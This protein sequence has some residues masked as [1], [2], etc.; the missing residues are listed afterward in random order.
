MKLD[1]STIRLS[2]ASL[3]RVLF[4]HPNDGTLMLALERKASIQQGAPATVKAQ[5]FGG[6]VHLLDPRP[7]EEILGK[8]EFDSQHSRAEADFRLLIPSSE[9]EAVKDF[10][11]VHLS[12]LEDP[13]LESTPHRE[14]AEEFAEA[15]HLHLRPDQYVF[16]RAGFTLE[17]HLKPTQNVYAAGLP[18]VRIYLIFEVRLVDDSLIRRI[19]EANR[20][21]SDPDLMALALEDYRNGGMGRINSVLT[22][23]LNLV[24]QAYLD[25]P[26]ENR[27]RLLNLEN[28]WLD[29]STLA[30][31]PGVE[32]EQYQRFD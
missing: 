29:V 4:P 2:V 14:L 21:Q 17:T 23:P 12:N 1:A 27:F 10:C 6:G 13:F 5:P 28:H 30:I 32:V 15:L 26:P 18:T 19:Q 11:L 7:L 9:W 22:L 20:S 31:L 24:T 25:L 8:I 3:D 16:R